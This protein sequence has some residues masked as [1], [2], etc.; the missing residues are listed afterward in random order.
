MR[1]YVAA[2]G[3]LLFSGCATG[4]VANISGDR[5]DDGFLE[6][7][8]QTRR[9]SLGK[10]RS[11]KFT[12]DGESILFLRSSPASPAQDLYEY[13]IADGSERVI[14]TA[15]QVLN[16]ATEKL[17]DEE[18]ARRER[19][20]TGARG[21]SS[22]RLS[23]DGR[24][25]LVPMSGKLYVYDRKLNS[26]VQLP[27]DGGYATSARF[28]PDGKYVSCVREGDLYV[29]DIAA[30]KQRRLTINW[31]NDD[32]KHG[33]AD[34]IAMEEMARY[35][36]YWWSPT[37]R[38]IAC[39]RTDTSAVERFHIMD[40]S[41]PGKEPTS[42]PYPRPGKNN[43][44]VQLDIFS[45]DSAAAST[46]TVRVNW[47]R[48]NYPYLA[49]IRWTEHAPLTILVQ[50]RDQTS[51]ALLAVDPTTGQSTEL[52]TEHDDAWVSLDQRMPHW[53]DD[54][55]HFLWTTERNGSWQLEMRNRDGSLDRVLTDPSFAFTRFV[56]VDQT[57][58]LGYVTA[59]EN[60]T[61]THLYRLP[62]DQPQPNPERMTTAPGVH[63]ALFARNH[64]AYLH[65]ASTTEGPTSYVVRDRAGNELGRI[66]S[67]ATDPPIQPN[68]QLVQVQA[69]RTYHASIVRP[70][71]FNRHGRYPVIL[72]V[73]AG[74][75]HQMVR[76][77]PRGYLLD[78]WM[79]DHGFIVV[80]IDGR[81]T[82]ARGRDWSR[83]IKYDLI[84][85]PL[86]DQVSA[87]QQL[88]REYRE[89]DLDHVGVFGWSFGGYFSAMAAIHRPDVFHAAVA[90]APVTDWMDYDT[91]YTE[92]FLGLPEDN[93]EAY[94]RSSALTDAAN[95]DRPLMLIHGTAD[96]NV[97]MSHSLK[98]S[99]AL[100]RAGRQHDFL[101]LVGVTHS[102]RDAATVRSMY[103]RIMSFFEFHLT[104]TGARERNERTNKPAPTAQ[105]KPPAEEKGKCPYS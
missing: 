84:D 94:T 39:Q 21:I 65:I 41:N 100:T 61:E 104:G 90:G 68:V 53:L 88:G 9:F 73:Y 72:R 85:I 29:I 86:A 10:P 24:R 38:M 58:G 103:T 2:V 6:A 89:L 102:P 16:G 95:L 37:S 97:Y 47:D 69:D 11:F 96:D 98:L 87:L 13:T 56:D 30:N 71:N 92:R 83:A 55:K 45:V 81:G 66:T 91:H 59:S 36:G 19:M 27:D 14:L 79:A 75:G 4:R 64:Q 48:D 23:K 32:I 46:A 54:G 105:P 70:E 50:S 35:R 18:I 15:E 22:Y 8:A 57:G 25:I 76:A 34:F 49:T 20:R 28:S 7:Y 44:D 26:F 74:P 52:L 82:P 78:Q 101:P 3:F 60:P 42:S 99:Q 1:F 77:T 5:G 67:V 80:R 51:E 33:L 31:G 12:P 63:R 17:T 43:A 62:L 40:P 93:E